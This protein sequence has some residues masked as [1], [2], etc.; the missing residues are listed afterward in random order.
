M[1]AAHLL[2]LAVAALAALP[3]LPAAS[4][5]PWPLEFASPA[6]ADMTG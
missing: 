1:R 3:A 6:Q 5:A 4:A 2:I